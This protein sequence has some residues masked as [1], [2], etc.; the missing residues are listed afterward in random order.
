MMRDTNNVWCV[1]CYNNAKPQT[2]PQIFIVKPGEARK[3]HFH[4]MCQFDESEKDG[5]NHACLRND[6]QGP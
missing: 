1:V 4:S 6:E 3:H 2:I 5:L